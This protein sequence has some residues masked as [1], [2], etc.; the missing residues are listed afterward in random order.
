MI[1]NTKI[2]ILFI[3]PSLVA[4]GAERVVSFIS[5]NIDKNKFTPVLLIAGFPKDSTYNTS[6]VK[7]IFLHKSRVLYALPFIVYQ[8]IKLNPKIVMSSIAHTNTAMALIS[9]LFPK[10]KF[11]GREATILSKRKNETSNKKW[12]LAHFF[13]NNYKNLDIIIC[14]SQDMAEDMILNYGIP[15][16]KT[17]IINNPI[18]ELPNI[19]EKKTQRIKTF[20]TVGRLTEVKGHIRILKLLSALKY[21]FRY[22]IIGDGSIKDVILNKAKELSLTQY[23]EHIPYTSEVNNFLIESDYFL[24]GSYV[25]GFPNALLESCVVGTPVIAFNVPGGTKEIVENGINGYLVENEEEFLQRL[26]EDKVWNPQIV[27]DS[28]YK[29]FNKEKIL[30]QYED[31]FLEIVKK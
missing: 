24:Q 22:I 13:K 30:K 9:P 10:T 29:K 7:T 17:C 19:K 16:Q 23:I 20:I 6:N 14:Q 1:N 2:K 4:G 12:S 28:V 18:S 31:L 5:Q 26:N 25:E 11:V 15:K 3:L 27:R 21:Q 8:L